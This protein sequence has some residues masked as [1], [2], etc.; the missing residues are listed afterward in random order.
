M[1]YGLTD[2]EFKFL[3]VNLISPMKKQGAR[4]FLFGS[5][6]N[7]NFKKFSDID[8]FYIPQLNKP[9]ASHFIYSLLSE[10]EDSDFPYKIDFVLYDDLAESYKPEIDS[11][12]IEL[13]A[14]D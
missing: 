1:K 7:G 5:R 9:I 4:V 8:L 14:L 2:L 13:S 10:I 12:K 6:A 3:K 11:Q